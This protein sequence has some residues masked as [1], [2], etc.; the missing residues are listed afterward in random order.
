MSS[1]ELFTAGEARD[2]AYINLRDA[3]HGRDWKAFCESLWSRYS[4]YADAHFL[5][6]IRI[7][8]HQRFWEMYLAVTF[9]DRGFTLYR[10]KRAGPEFGVD[11]GG[12]RYWFEAVAPTAGEGPDAVPQL[13]FGR[14]EASRVPQEQI[15]LRLTGALAAKSAKWSKDLAAGLVSGED[16]FIV[17]INDRDIRK[18]SFGGDMPYIAKALYGFGD[19]AVAFNRATME[20]VETRHQYRP[21]IAKVGGAQVS[22][23]AFIAKECP[24]VSA[25]LYSGVDAANFPGILGA[26]FMVL[27]NLEPSVPLPL[28]ALRFYREYWVEGEHLTMRDWSQPGE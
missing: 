3:D 4:P 13:Q 18:S 16:G 9:I 19:L 20:I 11:I 17:A 6:E 14:P 28:E 26:D 12:R 22:S 25:V 21:A 7:Q 15:I 10:H 5:D 27:H 8:F 23:K 1:P 2:P 24:Q